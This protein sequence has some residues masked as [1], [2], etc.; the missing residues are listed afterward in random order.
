M[1]IRLSHASGVVGEATD[2]L[3]GGGSTRDR[4][5]LAAKIML[6]IAPGDFTQFPELSV[7]YE[8]IHKALSKVTDARD[9]SYEATVRAMSAPAMTK[10]AQAILDL[11]RAIRS[12]T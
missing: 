2:I 3:A 9:G 5:L 1:N 7:L 10:V 6:G 11:D 4:L 8:G 12:T